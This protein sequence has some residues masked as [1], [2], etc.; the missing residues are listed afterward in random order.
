[1]LLAGI[2]YIILS[3]N[4]MG[5]AR[6]LIYREYI[7][8]NEYLVYINYIYLMFFWILISVFIFKKILANFTLYLGFNLLIFLGLSTSAF[9]YHLDIFPSTFLFVCL[10]IFGLFRVILFFIDIKK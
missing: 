10:N 4:Y 9:L 7:L 8:T 3:D 6:D 5:I 2:T 1:M